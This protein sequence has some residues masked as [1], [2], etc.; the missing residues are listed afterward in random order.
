MGRKLLFMNGSQQENSEIFQA[1]LGEI[2]FCRPI[3]TIVVLICGF[4]GIYDWRR[5]VGKDEIFPVQV[6]EIDGIVHVEGMVWRT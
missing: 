1:F 2:F 6:G 5:R 4:V 3:R